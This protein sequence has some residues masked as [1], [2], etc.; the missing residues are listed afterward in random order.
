MNPEIVNQWDIVKELIKDIA[1]YIMP[2]AAFIVSLIALKRSKNSVEVQLQLS[3]VEQKL[4]EYD[5]AL[6]PKNWKNQGTRRKKRLLKQG[7]LISQKANIN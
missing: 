4:K 5:L 1:I 7:L 2:I 3:E 6:K